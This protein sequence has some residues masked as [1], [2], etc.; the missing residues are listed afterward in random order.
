MSDTK[1]VRVT[2]P[3][4][5]AIWPRLN[6]PDTKYNAAGKYECK[7]AIDGDDAALA[8]IRATAERL[9]AAK[10]EE[11]KAELIDK[12]KK[13]LADKI[14]TVDLIRAEE[15]DET[16]EETGRVLIK[17]SMTAT[18]VSKKTGKP[19]KRKPD[20]FN[21]KG[22]LL[23]NPPQIGSGSVV[24]LSVEMFPYYA[25]ND[26]TV[27]VS[28]RLEGVQVIKLVTFGERDASGHGF[29]AEDDADDINDA[30]DREIAGGA[31]TSDDE[32]DEL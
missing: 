26:K 7:V 5:L 25:A 18:G 22:E 4:G 20:I 31:G 12:G 16:G 2:L 30:A 29:G 32:D 23:K 10:L 27:G 28:F 14:T 24:K 11:V 1:A 15:D 13:A 8:S 6:T 3:R 17:A 9:T 21:G 19:W